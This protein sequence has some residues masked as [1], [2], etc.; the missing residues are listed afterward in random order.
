MEITKVMKRNNLFKQFTVKELLAE[1]KKL[2]AINIEGNEIFFSELS[3]KQKNI[4][5]AFGIDEKNIK[6]SY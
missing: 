3:K 2:K 6:H 4:L 5:K 1:L